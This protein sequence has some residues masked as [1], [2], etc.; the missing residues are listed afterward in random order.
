MELLQRPLHRG[1][2]ATSASPRSGR[3]TQALT[4][5]MWSRG[6]EGTA[7]RDCL[8]DGANTPMDRGRPPS[9]VAQLS[10]GSE[11]RAVSIFTLALL[12]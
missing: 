10:R 11:G 8:E 4:L 5:S 12:C 6:P 1:R 7:S 3:V 9:P 2:L